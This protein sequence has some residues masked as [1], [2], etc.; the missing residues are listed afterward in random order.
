MI[1]ERLTFRAKYG[2]GDALATLM[3]QNV[4]QLPMPSG[5]VGARLY[6]DFTGPMFQ[7]IFEIDHADLNA[8]AADS[9]EQMGQYADARFQEWFGKM[10]ACTELGERQILNSE[11]LI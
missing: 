8:F 1:T 7:V 11:K 4:E 10:I 9:Q 5:V 6:T 3:R 2:Q